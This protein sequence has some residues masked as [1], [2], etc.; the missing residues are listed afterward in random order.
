M[1]IWREV[2]RM[3]KNSKVPPPHKLPGALR[4]G[5]YSATAVLPGENSAAFDKLHRAVIAELTPKGALEDDLVA[6]IARLTWRKQNLKTLHIAKLAQNRRSTVFN[7][8]IDTK[9]S[10]QT[11]TAI[12]SK[13]ATIIQEAEDQ[14]RE[15]FGDA[16]RLAQF[17][18]AISFEGLAHDLD[19]E[20]R[21]GAMIERCLKRLL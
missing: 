6:T 7:E 3:T 14:V 20:E 18:E 5:I 4:H 12:H 19:F 1:L 15:E 10:G 21:F 2:I 13:S 8:M 17:G 11:A 9:V 16:A